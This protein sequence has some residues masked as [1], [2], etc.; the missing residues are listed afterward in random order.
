MRYEE[1]NSLQIPK[2]G[3]GTWS[4]GGGSFAN[5]SKDEAGLAALRSALDLG[6]THF[7]TAEMYGSGHTEE[8]L[9]RAVRESGKPRE[10]L[11]IV[12]KVSPQ[13]LSYT[14]VLRSC[15]ASLRRLQ[16][17]YLDLYL[18]HWP[19]LGMKLPDSFRALNQLVSDGK[20]RHLGVSNFDL[21]LL[22]ESQQL[23]ATPLLTNQVPYSVSDHKYAR[24][25]VLAYCQENDILITAYSPLGQ[26]SFKPTKT[27]KSIAEAHSA[28]PQQVAIAWLVAQPRVI[29]IPMSADRVHQK[30]NLDAADIRLTPEEMDQLG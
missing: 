10:S 18:I 28:S 16:M 22:K 21:K 27:L 26:G 6:Y 8:L 15:E 3:F 30:Q 1:W 11:F 13:H 7:D 14:G 9:G 23:S 20:V 29:T 5:R 2:V 19:V 17:D 25:G 24:N 12:S 4:I